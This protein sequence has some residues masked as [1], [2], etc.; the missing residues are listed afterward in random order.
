MDKP[1]QPL[2]PFDI[3]LARLVD[4][5]TDGE[6]DPAVAAAMLADFWRELCPP[7]DTLTSRSVH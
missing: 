7:L 6:P 2:D 5:L 1:A 3:E 4:D